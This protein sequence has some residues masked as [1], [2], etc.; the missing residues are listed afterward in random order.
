MHIFFIEKLVYY[1]TLHFHVDMVLFG[2]EVFSSYLELLIVT[3][4]D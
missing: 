2:F 1:F 4:Y 3:C